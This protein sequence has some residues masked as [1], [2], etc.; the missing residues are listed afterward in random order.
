MPPTP[1]VLSADGGLIADIRNDF[2]RTVFADCSPAG[3][4]GLAPVAADLEAAALHWLR[5]EQ[6]FGGEARLI[7]SADMRYRGQ[8]CEI[9]TPI[10]RAAPDGADAGAVAEA[11]HAA[12]HRAHDHSDPK[13]EA[14]IVNLRLVVTGTAPGPDLRPAAETPGEAAPRARA[15][16]FMDGA[17]RRA[18]L[19][20]R[21]DPAPGQSFAGHAIMAQSGCTTVI[22]PGMSARVDG[23]GN[24]PIAAE[25]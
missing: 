7:R 13:A 14:Q 24:L 5:E 23:W 16:V 8:S 11:F 3:L 10:D 1:G 9:E 20:D 4:A 18:G 19:F 25:A 17:E 12:H 21:A 6:S 15:T 2:I 22:P